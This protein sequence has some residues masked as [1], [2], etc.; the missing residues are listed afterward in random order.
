MMNV[1]VSVAQGDELP[2]VLQL[3]QLAGYGGGVSADDIVLV[4]K[5]H[6]RLLGAVRLCTEADFKVLRGMQV[7]PDFQGQGI[8]R[9][10]L[11]G[12]VHYLDDSDAYCLP[13]AHL[14]R[15]YGQINFAAIEASALP[16]LL[17]QRL[18]GYVSAGQPVLAMKRS[19]CR[20]G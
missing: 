11:S 6:A 13:Y 1:S 14:L 10:L 3:Y 18:A 12:C 16:P 4:A 5:D 2:Q 17:S 19:P 15:F 8:G 9:M 7:H 20:S